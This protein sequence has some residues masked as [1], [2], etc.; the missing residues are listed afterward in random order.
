MFRTILFIVSE[1]YT[2]ILIL[3][4]MIKN[5]YCYFYTTTRVFVYMYMCVCER[6]REVERSLNKCNQGEIIEIF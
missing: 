3:K 5:L 1:K 6:R 2:D 4:R